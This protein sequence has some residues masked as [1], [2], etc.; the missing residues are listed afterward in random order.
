MTAKKSN[1]SVSI[2]AEIVEEYEDGS[3]LVDADGV[4]L[5]VQSDEYVAEDELPDLEVWKRNSAGFRYDEPD[6]PGEMWS[7]EDWTMVIDQHIRR[8]TKWF[9]DMCTGKGPISSLQK[10]R[11]HME[12]HSQKL[13]EK[14]ETPREEMETAT[15]GGTPEVDENQSTLDS[16]D[17]DG[18]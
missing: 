7:S 16:L 13:V 9:C 10:A 1:V 12:S 6:K 8:E 4:E 18:R 14:H 17:G 11:R 5:L 3:A 2:E 15:D